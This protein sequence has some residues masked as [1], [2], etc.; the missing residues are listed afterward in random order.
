MLRN[1]KIS[2]ELFN[3][4][5]KRITMHEIIDAIAVQN[6][7]FEQGEKFVLLGSGLA[8]Y[9]SREHK[10][11]TPIHRAPSD[12]DFYLY[13]PRGE[14]GRFGF[15]IS[16]D[17]RI[18]QK[19]QQSDKMKLVLQKAA[20][21]IG[22]HASENV[23][24]DEGMEVFESEMLGNRSFKIKKSWNKD[25]LREHFKAPAV[26]TTIQKV[27][28]NTMDSFEISNLDE[29]FEERAKSQYRNTNGTLDCE[30]DIQ[31]VAYPMSFLKPVPIDGLPQERRGSSL[32]MADDTLNTLA[33]KLVRLVLPDNSRQLASEM[34][35]ASGAAGRVRNMLDIHD[36]LSLR[37]VKKLPLIDFKQL[38]VLFLAH[39]SYQE[40]SEINQALLSYLQD[41]ASLRA[42]FDEYVRGTGNRKGGKIP[43]H[44]A[45]E[46][47]D[48]TMS[49][50]NG[51]LP[52]HD[53]SNGL[54][55]SEDEKNFIGLAKGE[56]PTQP[57][58]KSIRDDKPFRFKHPH[59]AVELL[60][61]THP[62]VFESFLEKDP[63][64]KQRMAANW[65]L[66]PRHGGLD[67]AIMHEYVL[68]PSKSI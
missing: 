26:N 50:M 8:S 13:E 41:R 61:N 54:G 45:A 29:L 21:S 36:I 57:V 59:M 3:E 16:N 49:L 53:A 44:A 25:E 39:L 7:V 33:L 2:R 68:P 66:R 1:I 43:A 32:I 31:V 37:R 38:R 47:I 11:A 64:F 4:L 20:Q 40:S 23:Y 48:E 27:L 15:R 14:K 55:L 62:K 34:S 24:N 30:V 18:R 46:I 65:N 67:D 9:E 17:E 22:G 6:D 19:E 42:A 10:E 35:R 58:A 28:G 51:M 52:N 63:E 60:A 12:I 5:L 56:H